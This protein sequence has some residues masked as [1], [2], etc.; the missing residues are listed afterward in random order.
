MVST[1]IKWHLCI[2]HA[3]QTIAMHAVFGQTAATLIEDNAC[4]QKS[5]HVIY[6]YIYIFLNFCVKIEAYMDIF[7]NIVKFKPTP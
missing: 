6:I 7:A 5:Y 4:E 1:N 2:N 3:I